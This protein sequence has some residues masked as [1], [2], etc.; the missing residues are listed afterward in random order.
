[1]APGEREKKILVVARRGKGVDYTE[2]GTS[3]MMGNDIRKQW[4]GMTWGQIRYMAMGWHEEWLYQDSDDEDLE[5][6]F[7]GIDP[8]VLRLFAMIMRPAQ[9]QL[10]GLHNSDGAAATEVDEDGCLIKDDTYEHV[11]DYEWLPQHTK[12]APD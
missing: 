7:Q 6:L 8:G 12:F 11:D 4:P 1:M 9:H 2:N 3:P 10:D 5:N